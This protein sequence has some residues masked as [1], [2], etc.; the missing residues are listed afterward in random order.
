[1]KGWKEKMR[2]RERWRL[3]LEEAK[4]HQY[5]S[6]EWQTIFEAIKSYETTLLSVYPPPLIFVRMLMR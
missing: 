2:N 6:A 1:V 3:I 4:A 5:C